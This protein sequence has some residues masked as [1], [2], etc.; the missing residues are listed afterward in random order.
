MYGAV[1]VLALASASARQPSILALSKLQAPESNRTLL[2]RH[3][4]G[5]SAATLL[6]VGSNL[7]IGRFGGEWAQR[8]IEGSP[9][10]T[11]YVSCVSQALIFPAV[12]AMALRDWA[13]VH[14]RSWCSLRAWLHSRWPDA[15]PW[16]RVF[17]YL[18]FGYFM[19]DMF[20]PMSAL[21]YAH[22]VLCLLLTVASL[23]EP[24]A[25]P[26]SA[27][28]F[29]ITVGLEIGSFGANV[30]RVGAP[31]YAASAIGLALMSASNAFA[32]ALA[33]WTTL[34]FEGG[35]AAARAGMM[36]LGWLLCFLRQ[37][38]E[39]R[40]FLADLAARHETAS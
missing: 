38:S 34:R 17:H 14:G 22:H 20:I 32:V 12:L 29:L 27:V 39:A 21:I 13:R 35:R 7:A 40:R 37:D 15:S 6:G 11:Y 18:V 26:C 33:A 28:F 4:L 10:Y 9:A 30:A 2:Q 25:L 23:V 5:L 1:A 24:A 16:R 19:K 36:V 31:S 3:A 8:E